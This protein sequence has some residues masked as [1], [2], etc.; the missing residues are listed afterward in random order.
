MS[1]PF[2]E[3]RPRARPALLSAAAAAEVGELLGGGDDMRAGDAASRTALDRA[4][5]AALRLLV[6][7][8]GPDD[9]LVGALT[10]MRDISYTLGESLRSGLL[11]RG[12][13]AA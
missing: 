8:G 6:T 3:V 2:G 13:S 12:R 9:C 7:R 10:L 1:R 5:V 11:V 4:A